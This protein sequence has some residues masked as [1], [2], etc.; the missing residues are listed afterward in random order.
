MKRL[1]L[2]LTLCVSALAIAQRLP[3]ADTA[4]D[5]DEVAQSV[6]PPDLILKYRQDIGLDESQSSALKEQVHKAQSQFLDLQWDMQGETAKL[7]QILRAYRIDESAM[8]AQADKVLGKEKQIKEAQ[9]LLL[10][11]LKNLLSKDQ[12][13]KLMDLRRRNP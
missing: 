10:T 13:E 1:L 11:R 3:A 12:Q 2:L 7:A 9:L 4:A 5:T 8:L 6:F